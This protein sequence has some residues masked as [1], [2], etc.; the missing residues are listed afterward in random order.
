MPEVYYDP[1]DEWIVHS[2]ATGL[3]RIWDKLPADL[4]DQALREAASA[5]DRKQLSPP[6]AQIIEDF[7]GRH[8]LAERERHRTAPPGTSHGELVE[9]FRYGGANLVLWK[10]GTAWQVEV[11]P[12]HW[13]TS[14][15]AS[16]YDAQNEA[17]LYADQ[18]GLGPSAG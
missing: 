6:A 11:E 8:R 13:R 5:S 16:R 12:G 15:H 17:E 10:I 14:Q 1:A 7:I 18:L 4:R 2:L 9:S 3:I